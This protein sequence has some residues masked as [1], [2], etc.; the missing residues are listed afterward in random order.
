MDPSANNIDYLIAFGSGVLMSLT[1]CV[2]PLIPVSAGNIGAR[3]GGSR[4]KGLVLSIVYVLGLAVTYSILG[5]I[6]TLT[7]TIFGRITTHPVTQIVVGS[8]IIVFGFSLLGLFHIH[9]PHKIKRPEHK[10][11]YLYTF[12]L[13]LSSGLVIS[14][15]LSPALGA[16]LAYLTTK[17]NLFYGATLLF[18]FALGMGLI[19]ILIGAFEGL[20]M[21]LPKSGKWMN[22]I[23]RISAIIIMI[24]GIYLIYKGIRRL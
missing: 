15:C 18:S 13:G 8:I 19:F 12:L 20:L 17:Q 24:V 3:A 16:I 21:N 4:L 11:D 5:L 1:P 2:Y 23:K 14:P 9:I 6:A 22:N 10:H 7:G